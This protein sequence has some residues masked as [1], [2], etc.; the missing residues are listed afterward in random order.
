[1]KPDPL[2]SL[3]GLWPAPKPSE[4][5]RARARHRALLALQLPDSSEPT[6]AETPLFLWSWRW[7]L[8]LGALVATLTV[9]W[10]RTP[11]DTEDVAGDRQIL[12]QMEKLFPNQ[13][14]AVVVQN[15]KVDLS[16]AQD[17]VVGTDQPILLVFKRGEETIRVL[18]YSGHHVCLA[19]G[20]T[21][22]C[23]EI[24]E[25]PSGGVIL[26]ADN[27]VWLS[28]SHPVMAGYSVR[29]Q[30]MEVPL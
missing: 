1:M 5:I 18:S 21:R 27:Q 8:V 22:N 3:P 24:L 25:T 13:V 16:I 30:V 15:G 29:A 10:L 9:L 7:T 6:H 17:P 20:N 2:K 23:F 4:S 19:L 11:G 28:S 14:D 26:E 12:R